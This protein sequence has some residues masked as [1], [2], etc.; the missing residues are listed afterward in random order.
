[1]RIS[2]YVKLLYTVFPFLAVTPTSTAQTLSPVEVYSAAVKPSKSW[3]DHA[4]LSSQKASD[5]QL[6]RQP[7]MAMPQLQELSKEEFTAALSKQ[8]QLIDTR[9]KE[10]VSTGFISGSIHIAAGE[11][12]SS[13]FG[14]LVK[15]R[16]P[17][18][19]IAKP[20]AIPSLTRELQALGWN[21]IYGYV[22][23]I[24][25][26]GI[27]IEKPALI[28]IDTY[29]IIVAG[30][31]RAQLVDVRTAVEF[32]KGHIPNEVNIPLGDLEKKLHLIDQDKPV[33]IHCQSGTRGTI[34]YSI[35]LKNGFKNIGLFFEGIDGWTA[36]GGELVQDN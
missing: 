34:A 1:M 8:V 31:H 24:D 17:I 27:P 25:H 21:D 2:K 32:K 22:T 18:I 33:I 23:H 15:N 26:L 9:P 36:A 3:L 7:V 5:Y 30:Q 4:G 19:L 35:L 10:E 12:F 20:R 14:A 6:D 29:K 11:K 13:F 28:N 16:Q